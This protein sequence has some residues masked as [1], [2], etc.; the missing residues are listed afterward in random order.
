[1]RTISL[2]FVLAMT[3]GC[4][5]PGVQEDAAEPRE[6]TPPQL[7]SHHKS[8][9]VPVA[10]CAKKGF[11]ALTE[12]G[13]SGVVRNGNYSYGNFNESRAAVK[14]VEMPTGSFVYF[15]VASAKKEAAEDLRNRISRKF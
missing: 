9:Q 2:V 5:G 11:D 13:F 14:C 8:L 15:A 3:S 10:E 6:S 7:W 1:L 4:A 12:L